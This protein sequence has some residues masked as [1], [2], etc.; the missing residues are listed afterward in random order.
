MQVLFCLIF[1]FI[2]FPIN[3]AR[4][5]NNYKFVRSFYTF[6]LRSNQA[7]FKNVKCANLKN[8]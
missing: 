4:T 2:F 5:F 8:F 3:R 6:T 1:I 7:C